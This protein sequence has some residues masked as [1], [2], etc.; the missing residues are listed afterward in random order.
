M[1]VLAD[2]NLWPRVVEILRSADHLSPTEQAAILVANLPTVADE[3]A[4]GS[5]VSLS[6]TQSE[7]ASSAHV[8]QPPVRYKPV[9]VGQLVVWGFW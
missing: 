6:T 8:G 3:L 4:C 7:G 2:A 1:R 5:V 9:R